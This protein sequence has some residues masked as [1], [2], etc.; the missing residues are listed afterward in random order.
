MPAYAF[1]VAE[2]ARGLVLIG[3]GT[4]LRLASQKVRYGAGRFTT[5]R[6]G[7]RWASRQNALVSDYLDNYA[8]I[9]VR[10]MTPTH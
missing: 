7:N 5:D 3:E 9:V 8:P 10:A 6:R 1:A 4:S 2:I